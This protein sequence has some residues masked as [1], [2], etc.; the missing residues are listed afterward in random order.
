MRPMMLQ[1]GAIE[2]KPN[3]LGQLA[4]IR[5][6]QACVGAG[7]ASLGTRIALLDAV[8][9][10]V[11]GASPHVRVRADH[12]MGLDG[13]LQMPSAPLQHKTRLWPEGFVGIATLQPRL[14]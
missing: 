8:D 2:I 5:F 1:T 10:S 11:V 4:D 3:A 7:R 13:F 9:Q 12:L 14:G 6:G